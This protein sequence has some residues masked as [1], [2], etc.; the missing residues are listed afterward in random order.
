MTHKARRNNTWTERER[1]QGERLGTGRNEGQKEARLERRKRKSPGKVRTNKTR[2][3]G[4]EEQSKYT[5]I[6]HKK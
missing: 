2:K 6:K 4:H 1:T 3:K 5:K